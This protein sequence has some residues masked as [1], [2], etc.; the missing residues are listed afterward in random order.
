MENQPEILFLP[1]DWGD[2]YQPWPQ[3]SPDDFIRIIDGEIYMHPKNHDGEWI[4]TN[5]DFF[6]LVDK[7]SI[8]ERVLFS[9]LR[10]YD[11]I[12]V[13]KHDDGSVTHEPPPDG[14][15]YFYM[16]GYFDGCGD[17][18]IAALFADPDIEPGTHEVEM[19]EE[20]PSQILRLDMV[21]GK[22]EFV[23]VEAVH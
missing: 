23:L 22:P 12:S 11:L 9:R 10:Y 4:S 21:D 5:D 19:I 16:T 14:I 15:T 13:I 20:L 7:I 6:N 8:G 18:T 17:T 1:M 3:T 2:E